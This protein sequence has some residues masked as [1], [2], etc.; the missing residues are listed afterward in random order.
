[1]R[2][3]RLRE[4]NL[5]ATRVI[6]SANQNQDNTIIIS[7]QPQPQPMM[8]EPQPMIM[9][10]QPMMMPPEPMPLQPHYNPG[11]ASMYPGQPVQATYYD[12]NMRAAGSDDNSKIA[13]PKKFSLEEAMEYIQKDEYLEITPNAIRM[14]KI[15]LDENTRLRMAKK[16]A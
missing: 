2:N 15:Y 1:M 14:R 8:M 16:E 12:P 9:Q 11:Y 7:S 3:K 5:A 6:Q 10:P 13:P 4:Q